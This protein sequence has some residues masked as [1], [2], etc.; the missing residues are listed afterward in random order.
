MRYLI[1]LI[2]FV[3]FD[4]KTSAQV[5]GGRKNDFGKSFCQ[6]KHSFSLLGITRSFGNGSDDFWELSLEFN[7]D[8]IFDNK[9]GW[10]THDVPSKIIS[11]YDDH[12]V[13][14]GESWSAPG[15][16]FRGDIVVRKK[17][18]LGN[19]IW[20]SYFGGR[21]NDVPMDI[22]ETSD[23]GYVF[24]GIDETGSKAG[25]VY[26]TKINEDGITEWSKK[27]ESERKDAGMSVVECPDSSLIILINTG[28][29]TGK[30]ANSSEY[31]DPHRTQIVLLKTNKNGEEIW[32]K[33]LEGEKYN[34][35]SQIKRGD[36][37]YY[38][39]SSSMEDTYGS[40][41]ISV[42]KINESGNVIWKKN[43]GGIDYDYAS[44]IDIN[45]KGE[46]L[47]TGTSSS[48]SINKDSDIYISLLDSNGVIKWEKYLDYGFSDYGSEGKFIF[49]EKIAVIG[50]IQIDNKIP[51]NHDLFFQ[52]FDSNGFESEITSNQLSFNY[53]NIYIYPNPTKSVFFVELP[54]KDNKLIEFKMYD[55]TGKSVHDEFFRTSKKLINLS[56]N[57]VQGVY[58]YCVTIES[59]T[60]SGKVIIN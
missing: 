18:A 7:L 36:N 54:N 12:V 60:I 33:Q 9:Y 27:F 31:L 10:I 3:L 34:F 26:L 20:V 57:L 19:L 24:T 5:Y 37:G 21:S 50:S 39:L 23:N 38:V 14:I 52:T 28:A 43:Y 29:F 13:T 41:D 1:L 8:S 17:D 35:G 32:R 48:N 15:P 16:G 53:T 25:K 22:I 4:L 47:I 49:N 11:T 59:E 51:K 56:E 44:S 46:L 30:V 55:I 58:I 45:S 40:F 6:L 42:Q 2:L